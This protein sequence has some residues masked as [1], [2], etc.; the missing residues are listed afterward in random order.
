[1]KKLTV[2]CAFAVLTL[3]SISFAQIPSDRD[4][5]LGAKGAGQAKYAENNGYPGPMHVLEMAKTI[6]L[7][8][9]QKEKVQKI[10]DEMKT[11]AIE[12]GKR[13][14]KIEE[15]LNAGFR[16]GLIIEKN[17]MSDAQDIGRLRGKLRAIHLIAHLK[18]KRI[19][20]DKQVQLYRKLREVD[21][22]KK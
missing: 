21:N 20:T 19:L 16:E 4:V 12:V 18:T 3:V 11:S 9:T 8:E 15:E 22:E 14:I 5:L 17:I 2:L 1:M 13:I 6:G 7:S 10:Y